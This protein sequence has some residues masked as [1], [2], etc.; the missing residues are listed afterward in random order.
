MI[1]EALKQIPPDQRAQFEPIIRQQMESIK[2]A[3][4]AELEPIDFKST[5]KSETIAGYKSTQYTGTDENGAKHEMWCSKDVLND[6]IMSFYTT[7]SSI[8]IFK[9]MESEDKNMELGFP[10]KTVIDDGIYQYQSEVTE[11]SFKT[12]SKELFSIPEGFE[13]TEYGF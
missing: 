11:I 3:P 10:L 2:E 5:G 4:G 12:V 1:E 13:E 9:E 7:I 6:E 8:E